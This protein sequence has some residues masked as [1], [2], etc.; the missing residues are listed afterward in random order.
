MV[1]QVSMFSQILS[2][3][4]RF[5]FEGLVVKHNASRGAK[6]FSCWSQ[7]VSMLF[8]QL[9]QA[10]SLR[11]I[12]NG[13]RCTLG[14][15]NH[16]G[17]NKAP[18]RSTLSYANE[19]RPWQ[20]YQD[21]FYRMLGRC[22]AFTPAKKF[23]FKNKLL[24]L[25]TTMI[26]LCLSLFPWAK[27]KRVKGAIKLHMLLDHD[28][29]LPAFMLITDGKAS[30]LYGARLLDLPEESVVVI[31]RSY[32]DFALF[33]RWTSEKV[34]FITRMKKNTVYEVVES[35][36]VPINRNVLADETIRFTGKRYCD[37]CPLRMRRIVVW[38]KQKN[39]EIVFLTNNMQL[40]A[41]TI[42]A[43]YKDRWQIEIFFKALKQNLKIKTFVGTSMNA[44]KI[45]IW[46]ALIAMLI[47]KYLQFRSRIGWS[48]SNL[49]ALLRWNLFSYR[50]LLDWIN[51]PFKTPPISPAPQQLDFILTGFGQQLV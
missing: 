36:P 23:R 39:C 48:M 3:F 34:W 14:K 1:N 8:C 11:E 35:N 38:D 7:F 44:L 20:L 21:L 51:D 18:A 26:D 29:Y 45:Q 37:K 42:S 41:T 27:Y 12:C 43:V 50:N 17:I 49:V 19:H 31:D 2:L 40:G 24:S 32:I 13:L 16:L 28:G 22:Q 25:D 9:A 5:E 15:L 4:P 46:T 10:K 30:D 47:L 33:R 6:G